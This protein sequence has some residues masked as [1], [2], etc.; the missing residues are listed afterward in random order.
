M[1]KQ[2]S[3]ATN[4][5][6]PHNTAPTQP[7]YTA[8]TAPTPSRPTILPH[9]SLDTIPGGCRDSQTLFPG[10]VVAL[11]TEIRELK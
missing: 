11:V 7:P 1:Q 5:P 6:P 9:K 2:N 3:I 8:P 10:G 4:L